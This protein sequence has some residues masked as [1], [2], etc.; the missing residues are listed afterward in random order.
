MAK[1]KKEI[2]SIKRVGVRY[3]R[4]VRHKVGKIEQLA[5]AINTVASS[6]AKIAMYSGRAIDNLNRWLTTLTTASFDKQAAALERIANAY[7]KVSTASRT[8]NVEGIQKTTEMIKALAYLS[9]VGGDN[10]MEKLGDSLISAVKELA[11]MIANFD[12]TVKEQG[13]NSASVTGGLKDAV[14][15]LINKFSSLGSSGG[16]TDS[17]GSDFDSDEVVDV[18]ERVLRQLQT[19]VKTIPA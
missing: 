4:L 15:G 1:N 12:E 5:P 16:S 17:G 9:E 10:A 3:G 13:N 8:M 18:L 2:G 11:N 7:T 6:L 19:G 14:S